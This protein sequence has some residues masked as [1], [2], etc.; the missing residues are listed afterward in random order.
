[1]KYLNVHFVSMPLDDLY[2]LIS[3][4]RPVCCQV[5]F[6]TTIKA[7]S[8]RLDSFGE[9]LKSSEC[10]VE[11]NLKTIGKLFSKSVN[12]VQ[13]MNK[14]FSM[15]FM[16]SLVDLLLIILVTTFLAYDIFV[17][18]LTINDVILMFG[19]VGYVN[20]SGFVCF[21]ILISSSKLENKKFKMI[22][23]INNL[24]LKSE[25]KLHKHFQLSINQLNSLPSKLSCGLFK[26][27]KS[28]IFLIISSFF[29][30]FIVMVQFDFVLA[31][32]L[33]KSIED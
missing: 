16:T 2:F 9:I 29:S 25:T 18:S 11:E 5:I 33:N 32:Q 28:H 30:Y 13:H 24:K 10:S 27:E 17:H 20:L 21:S 4:L 3:F 8:Y 12:A 22:I 1:M 26:F 15:L 6:L 14:I 19:G 7:L 31:K 23:E